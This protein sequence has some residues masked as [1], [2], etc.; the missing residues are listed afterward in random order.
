M[1]TCKQAV[2]YKNLKILAGFL[3]DFPTLRLIPVF[4]LFK[5][6]PKFSFITCMLTLES[7]C[8]GKYSTVQKQTKRERNIPMEPT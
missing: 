2:A 6:F 4:A 1:K 3:A 8:V 5:C 7:R